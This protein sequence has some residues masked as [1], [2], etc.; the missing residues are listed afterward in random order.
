M[1]VILL[2]LRPAGHQCR[3]ARSLCDVAE[4][5]TGNDGD[6][7]DDGYLID[8]TVCGI[9][10]QCWKGNCSDIEQQCRDLWGPGK[11]FFLLEN[12]NE[13][14]VGMSRENVLFNSALP[15]VKESIINKNFF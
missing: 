9:S 12:W 6:C 8:G 4:V 2:Q 10:G 14:I 11:S 7:P 5:C 1:L 15:T 13:G 3:P